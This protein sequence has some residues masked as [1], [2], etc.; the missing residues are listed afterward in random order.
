MLLGFDADSIIDVDFCL[1]LDQDSGENRVR[2]PIDLTVKNILISMLNATIAELT[3]HDGETI[4]RFELSEKYGSKESLI[5]PLNGEGFEKLRSLYSEENWLN[6]N[7]AVNRSKDLAYYFAVFRDDVGRKL[8]G[9]RRASQFKAILS[10]QNRLIR[11]ADDSMRVLAENIFRLDMD[12]DFLIS[13]D[14]IFILRPSGFEFISDVSS[15]AAEKAKAKALSL[16]SILPFID[17]IAIAEHAST[18]RRAA[19]L[20]SAI[21]IRGDLGRIKKDKLADA[22]RDNKVEL[23]EVDGKLVPKSGSE[24]G[25]LELLDHRRYTTSLTDDDPSAFVASSRQKISR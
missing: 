13:H 1:S 10:A 8:I 6:D 21:A 20:V 12:F 24:L 16:A 4:A 14:S 3:P 23:E 25:L 18:H 17:F 9:V 22:A 5:A 7:D 2:I 19:R 15:L 11:W